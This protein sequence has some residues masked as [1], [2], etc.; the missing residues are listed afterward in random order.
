MVTYKDIPGFPG[1]RVGDDGSVW[2]R[3]G[4]GVWRGKWKQLRRSY[5]WGGYAMAGISR[6][7]K[8]RT[9]PVH[10]L[11]LECFVGPRPNGLWAC[12][13]DGNQKNNRLSNLRWD[14]PSANMADC[15]RHGTH[16]SISGKPGKRRKYVAIRLDN[17]TLANLDYAAEQFGLKDR[18]EAIVYVVQKAWEKV[19]CG[20]S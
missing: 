9:R 1:Y 15:L 12:H 18:S 2:S 4:R 8:S 13:N 3:N 10:L 17:A 7:G 14:T 16:T 6:N 19:Q 20:R 5:N 11:V